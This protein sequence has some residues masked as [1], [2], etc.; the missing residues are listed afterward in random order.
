MEYVFS[1]FVH[2]RSPV[3]CQPP[4]R[5][6]WE[7]VCWAADGCSTCPHPPPL[8]DLA[9]WAP[10]VFT[11]QLQLHHALGC[12]CWRG[13]FVHPTATLPLP[14]HVRGAALQVSAGCIYVDPA[15]PCAPP[16]TPATMHRHAPWLPRTVPWASPRN[17]Y[18]FLHGLHPPHARLS[19]PSVRAARAARRSP[20]RA[21]HIIR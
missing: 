1:F 20:H 8:A 5:T 21:G 3:L 19:R 18:R 17:V 15:P 7:E 6:A 13:V 14:D 2:E 16:P 11:V 9:R 4:P 12:A 10:H